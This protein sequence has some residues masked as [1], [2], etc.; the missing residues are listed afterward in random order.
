MAIIAF[1]TPHLFYIKRNP[2]PNHQY[3]PRMPLQHL[4][5]RILRVAEL[6]HILHP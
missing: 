5:A 1:M 3:P 4:T 2:A 6:N